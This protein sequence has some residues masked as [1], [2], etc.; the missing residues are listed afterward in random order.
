MKKLLLVFC[1]TFVLCFSVTQVYAQKQNGGVKGFIL[2]DKNA[3]PL[4]FATVLLAGTTNG[5]VTDVNGFFNIVNAQPGSYKL[6]VKYIGYTSDTSDITI[7]A[8]VTQNIKIKL[9]E[10]ESFLTEIKIDA[11]RQERKTQTQVSTISFNTK[12]IDKI[13]TIGGEPE[14]AQFLQIIPGIV[15]TGDQGGQMYVRGGSAI[16]TL[17]LLDGMPV[18]NPFHSIG[19]Y[20]V[21]ETEII[22]NVDVLT[23]GFP[24]EYGNRTSA[25]IDVTTRDGNKKQISGKVSGNPF[26]AKAIVEG[27]LWKYKEDKGIGTF[28]IT[29]KYSYIDKTAKGIYPWVSAGIPYSF[30]DIYAKSTFSTKSGSKLELFGFNFRDRANFINIADT[31]WNAFGVGANFVLVPVKGKFFFNT[32]FNYSSYK[33]NQTEQDSKPRNTSIGGFNL[34]MN[35]TYYVKNGDIK[36]GIQVTGYKTVMEF[37]NGLGYKIDQNQN[38]TE[39]AAYAKYRK[40]FG[41]L[42]FEPSIRIQYYGSLGEFSPEPRLRLKYN[43]HDKFRIKMATGMYS[44][45]FISTKSDRDVVNLFNGFLSGPEDQLT[46]INGQEAKSKLQKAI[47]AIVGFEYEPLNNLTINLEPYFIYNTQLINI[48][49]NKLFQNDPNYMIE[50]GYSYGVDFL[51][52][53]ESKRLFVWLGYSLAWVKRNDGTQIYPPHFDRRHNVN[54]SASYSFGKKLNW[55]VSARFNLGSGFPF[56]RTSGFYEDLQLD[57]GISNNIYGENGNVGIM[58]ETKLNNG[59]LPIYHRL[60][61]GIKKKWQVGKRILIELNVGVSNV[62]NRNNLFYINRVS[63]EKIYQLPILPSLG[64]S[65]K[66]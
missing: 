32:T 13:P 29:G 30:Q 50:K 66:F 20:S 18:Y 8:G 54:V 28:I 5:S 46:K 26:M 17:F 53:Y 14:L 35:F 60:D 2:N 34:A 42:V 61:L 12:T 47:H 33:L 6:V 65:F 36:Y 40:N 4:P 31:R 9:K 41:K 52:K 27:P 1:T 21:Y 37:Y 38:T 22:K 7:V 10:E 15:F 11:K 24:A 39:F 64:F 49:R 63:Q 62:Y 43:V 19:L 56:T 23:G 44:Q 58:Y 51:A 45:N 57:Q 25:V 55:E 16:N 48:N 59:R 3:E